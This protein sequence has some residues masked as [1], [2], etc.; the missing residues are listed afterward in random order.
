MMM[1]LL[2]AGASSGMVVHL[3]RDDMSVVCFLHGR[4]LRGSIRDMAVG[5]RHAC[6]RWYALLKTYIAKDVRRRLTEIEQSE[7]VAAGEITV[8][9]S[10]EFADRLFFQCAR[11]DATAYCEMD[12]VDLDDPDDTDSHWY[13]T[14][15]ESDN[16]D[17]MH[18]HASPQ[19]VSV[20]LNGMAISYS[21]GGIGGRGQCRFNVPQRIRYECLQ[22][23]IDG[24][25]SQDLKL[26]DEHK[27]VFSLIV[28]SLDRCCH[29]SRAVL[30]NNIIF[31]GDG[32][33]V[34]GL[35]DC[36][37]AV[38][39]KQLR[40]RFADNS[41]ATCLKSVLAPNAPDLHPAANPSGVAPSY[42]VWLGGSVFAS[43]KGNDKSFVS[44]ADICGSGL[45]TTAGSKTFTASSIKTR[46]RTTAASVEGVNESGAGNKAQLY[47]FSAPDW[48]S[49]SAVAEDTFAFVFN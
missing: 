25:D 5:V 22:C 15:E 2:A 12:V 26:D 43:I 21:S 9:L 42:S 24:R 18:F 48:M 10:R 49:A 32:A 44:V 1:P 17:L 7:D 29:E 34:E 28:A 23:L 6:D 3:G 13:S 45:G 19:E 14:G 46:T 11:V 30:L 33:L 39:T 40:R 4:L 37:C 16:G 38:T 31:S 47:Q 36:I 27:G 8:H 41:P 35:T 20:L